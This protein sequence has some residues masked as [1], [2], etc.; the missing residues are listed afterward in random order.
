MCRFRVDGLSSCLAVSRVTVRGLDKTLRFI[1]ATH[2]LGVSM[3]FSGV[4]SLQLFYL[5]WIKILFG[6][7]DSFLDTCSVEAPSVG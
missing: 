2:D 6:S 5:R 7:L 1:G 4:V 3:L